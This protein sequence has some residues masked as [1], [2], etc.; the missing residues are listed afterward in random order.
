MK[1]LAVLIGWIEAI[2]LVL[3]AISI[4]ISGS[5]ATEKLGSPIIEAIIYITF[6]AGI[7]AIARGVDGGRI[8]AR[9]PYFLVQVFAGII[10]Y[11]LFSGDGTPVKVVGSAIGVL[12]I[13]GVVGLSKSP[14]EGS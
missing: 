6:A 7:L 2:A 14:I 5:R 8:W 13:L 3:N 11:T 9:T 12:A 1:R 10:A 4:V